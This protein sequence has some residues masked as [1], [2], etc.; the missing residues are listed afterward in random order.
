MMSG[1]S[2][3][4]STD[5]WSADGSPFLVEQALSAMVDHPDE[6]VWFVDADTFDTVWGNVPLRDALAERGELT[7][8]RVPVARQFPSEQIAGRWR[9]LY[10]EARM[11]G[12]AAAPRVRFSPDLEVE[13]TLVA[14]HRRGA[15]AGFAVFA[16]PLA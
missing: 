11:L 1:I 8:P 2:E 16:K 4:A 9:S 3:P 15:V 6:L 14:V 10:E 12:A 5:E 7:I 13:A